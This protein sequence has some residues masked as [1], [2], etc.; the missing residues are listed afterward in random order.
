MTL[1]DNT[2]PTPRQRLNRTQQLTLST[3]RFAA[4]KIERVVEP[5]SVVEHA[6]VHV[7]LS[8]LREVETPMALF[9][10]HAVADAELSLVQSMVRGGHHAEL[11]F[12]VLD[13][14]FLMRWNELVA[15]GLG[16]EELPPLQPRQH[17]PTS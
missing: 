7:V 14:A 13:T 6:A 15:D 8:I 2:V 4:R 11:D 5:T 9:A 10:R 17:Q 1:Q 3:W 16:P 12:D